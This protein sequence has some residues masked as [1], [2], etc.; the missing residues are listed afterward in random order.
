MMKKAVMSSLVALA[1]GVS[2]TWGFLPAHSV[3]ADPLVPG[4]TYYVAVDGEDSNPGTLEQPWRTIQK[5]GAMLEPGDT[6]VIRGGTYRESVKPA[7]SGTAGQPITFRAMD[8]EQVIISG[9]EPVSGWTQHSGFIYKAPAALKLGEEDQVYV[10]GE[11]VHV[12]RWPNLGGASL[13]EPPLA[14]MEAVSYPSGQPVTLTDHE[15]PEQDWTGANVWVWSASRWSAWTSTVTQSA[16]QSLSFAGNEPDSSNQAKA[17]GDYYLSGTLAALDEPGEMFYDRAEQMLYLWAPGSADP[18]QLLV[19]AKERKYA[20][21]L[22][23]RSYIHLEGIGAFAGSITTSQALG[24]GSAAVGGQGSAIFRTVAGLLPSQ[25]YVLTASV[26]VDIAEGKGSLGVRQHGGAAVT[27]VFSNLYYKT[28]TVEFTTGAQSTS[29]EIFLQMDNGIGEAYGD[30]FN[31]KPKTGSAAAPVISNHDFEEGTLNGWQGTGGYR[32]VQGAEYCVLDRITALYV[33]HRETST[34]KYSSQGETGIRIAGQFNELK[35]SVISHSSGR[36]VDIAGS[37]HRIV[38]NEITMTNYSGTYASA[39][40]VSGNGHLISHNTAYGSGRSILAFGGGHLSNMAVQYNDF[41]EGGYLSHDLGLVYGVSV[42]AENVEIAYNRI[43]DNKATKANTGLYL[44]NSSHNFIIH[45]NLIYNNQEGLRLNLP[46]EFHLVYNNTFYGNELDVKNDWGYVFTQDTLGTQMFNNIF[47]AE[48]LYGRE[49]AHGH[50]LSPAVSPLFVNPVAGDF[51]LQAGSSAIDE[52]IALTGITEGYTG[53]KPDLGALEYGLPAWSAGRDFINPPEPGYVPSEASYRN[54]IRNSGFERQDLQTSAVQ[55]I[56]EWTKTGSQEAAIVWGAS[57]MS[58]TGNA[59][60]SNKGLRLGKG[61]NGVEQAIG[62]LTPAARHHLFVWLKIPE[63]ESAVLGARTAAGVLV[64]QAYPSMGGEWVR[65]ELVFAA[66]A[67]DTGVIVYL[68]KG[69]GLDYVYAD[70]FGLIEEPPVSNVS[71]TANTPVL[72]TGSS[73]QLTARMLPVAVDGGITWS[74]GNP[75]AAVV[76]A[77]GRVTATGTGNVLLT[78]AS[79]HDP[80]IRSDYPLQVIPALPPAS[81]TDWQEPLADQA[82]W[83]LNSLAGNATLAFHHNKVELYGQG[84]VSY[85][86]G[87]YGDELLAFKTRLDLPNNDMWYGLQLGSS[88]NAQLPWSGNNGYLLVVKKDLLELQKWNGGQKVLMSLPNTVLLDKTWHQVKFGK[89]DTLYGANIR[90]EVD[91]ET[92]F[93]YFDPV[94]PLAGRGYFTVINNAKTP[95]GAILLSPAGEP[96]P[97]VNLLTNGGF[98]NGTAGWTPNGSS[99]TSVTEQVYSGAKAVHVHNRTAAWA[100][101]RQPV[102]VDN[103]KTYEASAL[104]RMGEGTD[105]ALLVL[106]YTA[107]GTVKYQTLGMAEA[108]G[109]QWTRVSGQYT[110][111]EAAAVTSPYLRIYTSNTTGSFYADQVRLEETATPSNL[112]QNPGFENGR[113]GWSPNG[114]SIMA[115]ASAAHSG[116]YSMKVYNRTAPWANVRQSVSMVNGQTYEGSAWVKLETGT[117]TVYLTAVVKVNG[118]TYYRTIASAAAGSTGWVKLSGRHTFN[119]SGPIGEA[120]LRLYTGST[121]NSFFADDMVLEIAEE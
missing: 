99:V 120:E 80:L 57:M 2:G 110:L 40:S 114:S 33:S 79:V 77:A 14:V 24:T 68:G 41:Y 9:A 12:A 15:L 60:A 115:D 42:D 20:F 18:N 94:Q 7:R 58:S 53:S 90:L 67:A 62:G 104:V 4:N 32:L 89:L 10:N 82:H 103:G 28:V 117:D 105:T 97:E 27:Q 75:S 61:E 36:G 43:H 52:G 64:E 121:T 93:S 56:Y 1:L 111:R 35:N 109:S 45:H 81:V 76:D 107:G 34:E 101:I 49:T 113:V 100:N 91:G 17:G 29:A 21:D 31:I 119:E 59:R 3:K 25:T 51:R 71:I 102:A 106:E 95:N 73:L 54:R 38:N 11:A 85:V 23:G 47:S 74:S 65:Q 116:Q 78:A 22:S 46:A 48:Q 8:D 30:G 72:E 13:L 98:E 69:A 108:T 55:P 92:V 50:N 44:D 39:L 19:E 70:D 96:D 37:G 118:T 66:G 84:V 83:L 26:K 6:A 5:A 112:L 88:S 63:G 16:P 87:Q 86:Y